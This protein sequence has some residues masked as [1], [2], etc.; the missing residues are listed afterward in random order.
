MAHAGG[1][2]PCKAAFCCA[3]LI[4]WATCAVHSRSIPCNSVSCAGDMASRYPVRPAL[5]TSAGPVHQQLQPERQTDSFG[6]PGVN[7]ASVHGCSAR[8]SAHHT[9]AGSTEESW[10]V[11]ACVS[12]IL[13]PCLTGRSAAGAAAEEEGSGSSSSCAS[14]CK[15][16]SVMACGVIGCYAVIT[17]TGYDFS[18][19]CT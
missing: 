19:D 3:D 18:E 5:S 7:N 14:P 6:K 4:C 12:T 8:E 1:A 10:M 13:G 11:G 2:C 16:S 15:S 17:C 9:V